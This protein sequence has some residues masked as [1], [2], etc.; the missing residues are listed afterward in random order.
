MFAIK[1][2]QQFN[3]KV[4]VQLPTAED[5]QQAT[6]SLTNALVEK[7]SV[8]P[9]DAG[10][11]TMIENRLRK[12]NMLNE[13]FDSAPVTNLFSSYGNNKP[14][15]VLVGHVDVVPPGDLSNWHTDPFVPVEKDGYL[16]GR[17]S[18]D[19][20]SSVAAMV[21]ALEEFEKLKLHKNIDIGL[22]LTSDEEGEATQG[23]KYLVEQLQLKGKRAQW[24]LVGE[25]SSEETLGDSIKVGRRGSLTGRVILKG[26]Q[27]HVGYPAQIINPVKSASKLLAKFESKQWD[28]P[29][30]FF[31]ATSFQTVKFICDSGAENISPASLEFIFNLRYSPKQTLEKLRGYIEKKI[32]KTGLEYEI[33]WKVDAEPFLTHRSPIRK[34][35]EQV[36]EQE[37]A[38]SPKLSTAGGTSDGR[39]FAKTGTHV[40]ELGL[41]NK[42]IHQAN[43]RVPVADLGKLAALYLNILIQMNQANA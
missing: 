20:K 17:G 36:I 27:G 25:P 40:V 33:E 19:M 38:I 23:V 1:R 22:V 28:L 30:R 11:L 16:Y 6:L 10:C 31:P 15:L 4:D 42:T 8:T 2:L 24:A 12:I 35:V 41:C 18:V 21:V 34:C 7:P 39:F 9:N 3:N 26:R 37:L 13:R 5:L 29:S 14:L 43:E 32:Q